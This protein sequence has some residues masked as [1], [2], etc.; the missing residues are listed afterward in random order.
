MFCG[1]KSYNTC[2]N[3]AFSVLTQPRNAMVLS[4]VYC[5][6]DDTLFEV[7]PEIRGSFWQEYIVRLDVS[8]YQIATVVMETTQPVLS[9]FTKLLS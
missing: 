5:P 9:Q 3:A 6:A 1:I 4:L 7:G 2:S 8:L